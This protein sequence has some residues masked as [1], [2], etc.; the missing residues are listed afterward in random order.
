MTANKGIEVREELLKFMFG[1]DCLSYVVQA[2]Q[3]VEVSDWLVEAGWDPNPPA[4][5]EDWGLTNT[6][7]FSTS[8]DEVR[9]RLFTAEQWAEAEECGLTFIGIEEAPS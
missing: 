3:S 1:G 7:L 8:D 4:A 2:P 9:L 5:A 6:V